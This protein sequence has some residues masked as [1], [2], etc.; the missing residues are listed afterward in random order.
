MKK[1]LYLCLTVMLSLSLILLCSCVPQEES[2]QPISE[3][4]VFEREK[5]SEIVVHGLIPNVYHLSDNENESLLD[6]IESLE[7]RITSEVNDKYGWLYFIDVI[8]EDG[9][10][11]VIA[12]APHCITFDGNICEAV[13]YSPEL[14][15]NFF[16]FSSN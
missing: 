7:P 6:L 2:E 16:P 1:I 8:H 3:P 15:I 10:K 11:I 9:S 12:I 13:G 5:I 4:Y 14:F